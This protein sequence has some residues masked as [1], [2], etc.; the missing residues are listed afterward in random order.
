MSYGALGGDLCRTER[1]LRSSG[2]L[3]DQV[4]TSD[5][6]LAD[7]CNRPAEISFWH[8][9]LIQ[10]GSVAVASEPGRLRAGH[11]DFKPPYYGDFWLRVDNCSLRGP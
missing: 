8:L 5:C 1:S 11:F 6:L 10:Q 4:T 7:L 3:F 2:A 9:T